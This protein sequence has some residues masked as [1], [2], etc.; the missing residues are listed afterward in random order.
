MAKLKTQ[1]KK[2]ACILQAEI[3]IKLIERL[4]RKYIIKMNYRKTI[5]MLLKGH[6]EI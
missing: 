2:L 1:E 5:S 3:L 6:N 4:M